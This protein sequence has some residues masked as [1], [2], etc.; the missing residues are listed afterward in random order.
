MYCFITA[1]EDW[2]WETIM[3]ST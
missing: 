1:V 2:N 3:C